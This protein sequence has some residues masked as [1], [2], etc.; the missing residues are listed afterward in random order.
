MRLESDWRYTPQSKQRTRN[1]DQYG[2]SLSRLFWPTKL[3]I[4]ATVKAQNSYESLLSHDLGSLRLPQDV[5]EAAALVEEFLESEKTL[6][7]HS[8]HELNGWRQ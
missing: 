2:H 4:V 8:N 3:K 7:S 5:N 1:G 6:N